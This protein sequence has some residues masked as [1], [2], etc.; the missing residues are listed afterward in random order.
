[1]FY[2]ENPSHEI[3]QG[4]VFEGLV[5]IGI[6][7]SSKF[8]SFDVLNKKHTPFFSVHVG[9]GYSVIIT[10]CCDIRKRPY[11]AFCP[12]IPV[13]RKIRENEFFDENP[14]RLNKLVQPENTVSKRGWDELTTEEKE[15]KLLK[16]TTYTWASNFVFDKHNGLFYDYLMIDF[17]FVF[18]INRER[19]GNNDSLLLSRVLQLSIESRQALRRKLVANYI[20]NPEENPENMCPVS[21]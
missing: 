21:R 1:M 20:R 17:N 4:D 6:I 19:L 15:E 3:R 13:H 16:G 14:T 7:P 9:F 12:L 18:N 5:S 11:L 8:S 10:P 2:S